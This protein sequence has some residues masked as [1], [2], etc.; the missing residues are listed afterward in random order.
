M[1]GQA[2]NDKEARHSYDDPEKTQ[3]PVEAARGCSCGVCGSDLCSGRYGGK[4]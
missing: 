4:H 1:L 3:T 2:T